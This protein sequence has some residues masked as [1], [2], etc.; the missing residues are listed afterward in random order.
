LKP[1]SVGDLFAAVTPYLPA[2][3]PLLNTRQKG[4][5]MPEMQLDWTT[6]PNR[7]PPSG[8]G[9]ALAGNGRI[10]TIVRAQ[11]QRTPPVR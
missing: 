8:N 3:D 1:Y 7:V 4:S 5:G 9:S 2:D 11:G 10:L 6:L